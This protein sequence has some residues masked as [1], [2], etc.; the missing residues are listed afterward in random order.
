MDPHAVI[1]SAPGMPFD[2]LTHEK[3]VIFNDVFRGMRVRII[4]GQHTIWKR[5]YVVARMTLPGD[6]QETFAECAYELILLEWKE[7]ERCARPGTSRH[8]TP[9]LVDRFRALDRD[10]TA[11][12]WDCGGW[13][14]MGDLRSFRPWA[15]DGDMDERLEC[16][17]C[18]QS[19]Y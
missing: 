4:G 7:E 12:C 14:H 15:V 2:G 5:D 11:P 13:F 19:L 6:R 10:A 18:Y 8:L 16:R 9:N 17:P 1:C 3:A